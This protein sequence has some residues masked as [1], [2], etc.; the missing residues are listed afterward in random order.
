VFE[1]YQAGNFSAGIQANGLADGGI[2]WALDEYNR[3]LIS[4]EDE[5]Q[6]NAI[7]KKIIAGEIVVHDYMADNSCKY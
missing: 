6:L 7:A 1:E 4:A 2:E 3:D 5:A